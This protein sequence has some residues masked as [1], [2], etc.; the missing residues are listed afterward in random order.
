MGVSKELTTQGPRNRYRFISIYPIL[1]FSNLL[2]SGCDPGST[3]RRPGP[4]KCL[5]T[6]ASRGRWR[7]VGM[8]A[9][10]DRHL[11][12]TEP[13]RPGRGKFQRAPIATTSGQGLRQY[14]RDIEDVPGKRNLRRNARI[15]EL[16]VANG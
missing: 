10:P 15:G 5:G 2:S 8:L 1:E 14:P 11:R 13:I 9:S 4:P 3:F 16:L 12:A 7:F 6:T